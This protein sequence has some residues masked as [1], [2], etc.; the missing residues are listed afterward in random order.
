M[1][2]GSRSG[3]TLMELLIA[4]SLVSLLSVG[5]LMAMRVGLNAM[6]KV[7][8]RL[9]TNRRVAGAQRILEQQISD[10]IVTTA[11]CRPGPGGPVSKQ[12]FFEGHPQEMRFV[13]GYSLQEAGRGYPRILEY[14]VIPREG[15]EGV[16]LVV[17]EILYTGP[18][19]TGRLCVG[20]GPPDVGVL[21]RPIQISPASF[22]LIDKLAFCRFFYQEPA[23]PPRQKVWVPVWTAKLFPLAIRI[24]M[25]PLGTAASRLPVVSLTAPVRVN[26]NPAFVY[27]N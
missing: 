16:R 3:V 7:N 23:K 24:E 6:E 22:V 25:A 27:A 14:R 18:D 26:K 13:S 17:N 21:F 4:V 5:I 12:P 11:N 19:S 1:R 8:D 9:L 15:N 2:F 10:L 20:S